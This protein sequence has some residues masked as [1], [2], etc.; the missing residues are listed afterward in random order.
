MTKK[1]LLLFFLSFFSMPFQEISASYAPV[2]ERLAEIEGFSSPSQR[3]N[4]PIILPKAIETLNRFGAIRDNHEMFKRMLKNE[5]SGFFSYHAGCSSYRIFQDILKIGIEEWLQIPIRE[6]FQFLRIPGLDTTIYTSADDFIEKNPTYND[7]L[8]A[9]M[10]HIM[11]LN[12]ALYQSWNADYDFSPRY[13]LQNRPWTDVSF[14]TVLRQFFD[15]VGVDPS[16]IEHIF[17][18]ARSYVPQR[19]GFIIQFF[20]TSHEKG[21]F[22]YS[23]L[24]EQAYPGNAGYKIKNALLPSQYLI[25]STISYFPQLRLVMSNSGTLNPYSPIEMIRYDSMSPAQELE[26]KQQLQMYM[27]TLPFDQ[28][29][30][31]WYKQRLLNDWYKPYTEAYHLE[32]GLSSI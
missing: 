14:S 4:T 9:T 3:F 27:R 5:T 2:H 31:E 16:H 8:H 12:I 30:A 32:I 23:F 10:Q 25:H 17:T 11:S 20:D 6:N 22:P 15:L 21:L 18:I 1:H 19:E 13:F 7:N 24:N 26:Y 29:K 28:E